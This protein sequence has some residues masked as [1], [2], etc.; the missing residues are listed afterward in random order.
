M[1]FTAQQIA[2][3]LH[4]EVEG[5]PEITVSNISK[6]EEGKEGTL[7]FLANPKYTKYIYSTNASIL[8]INKDF[9]PENK[10]KSTLIRVDDAYK[11][12][13]SLL[14]FYEQMTKETKVGVSEKSHIEDSAVLGENIYIGPFVY[15][16]KNVKIEDNVVVYPNTFI[17]DNVIVEQ[18][19]LIYSG[20]NIYKDSVIGENC[21]IHSG[22]VI[23]S[24]GFGFVP[25]ENSEFKKIPQ[26]GNVVIENNVEIGANSTIDRSSIGSTLIKNGVKLD[27]LVQI[28]HGVEIGEN[29][30]IASQ[31]GISGS[32]KLGKN[33]MMG[34][35]SGI[36]GHLKVADGVKIGAMTGLS[37][38]VTKENSIMQGIPAVNIRNFYKSA[39]IHNQLPELKKQI[40]K[41]T[42]QME[43]L[44]K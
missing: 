24:D 6:I 43:A 26:S 17:G 3:L 40:D 27:N 41:L 36:V 35:Q 12:F 10:I 19:T 1:K 20:V 30:V 13:A 39:I 22:V 32:T 14:E 28:A 9:K 23:G 37:K 2:D 8:I 7:S 5:N 21:I 4:G 18:G 42:K 16:G 44:I 29:T 38:S 25:Q 33:C 31:T 34:G 15:I 11:A